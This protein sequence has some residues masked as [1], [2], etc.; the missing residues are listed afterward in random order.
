MV[1]EHTFERMFCKK[2]VNVHANI[3]SY[4]DN[5]EKCHSAFQL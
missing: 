2:N 1:H 5:N 4:Y 3:H